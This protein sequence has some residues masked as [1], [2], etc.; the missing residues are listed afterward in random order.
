MSIQPFEFQ[1]LGRVIFGP[2]VLSDV[3]RHARQWGRRALV[4]TGGKPARA[5][6]LLE[7]L[8]EGRIS[9]HCFPIAS[10]PKISDVIDGAAQGREFRA[11][12]V[13]AFG[14]GSVID[15]AK[16]IAGMLTNEGPL[17]DYLE[18]VGKGDPLELPAAPWIAIPTTAGTGAEVTRNAVLSVPERHLKVSLRSNH[19][20]APLVLVDPELCLSLPPTLTAS[21]GM[22]ALTQ[23]IEPYVSAKANPMTDAYCV[24]GIPKVAAALPLACTAPT[25]LAARSALSLG[26][27]WSGIALTNAGLGAVHGFASPL[28]GLLGA[29]HGALCG[30]L[31]GPVMRVNIRALRDL[32]PNSPI[33]R[34]YADVAAWL[35]GRPDAKPEEGADAATFLAA[36]LGVPRL[37]TY[38]LHPAQFPEL[39][40]AAL[41][42]SSMKANPVLLTEE[43]LC[44]CLQEAF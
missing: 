40:Q 21:T 35:T 4:V 20:F 31:L 44:T 32:V 12:M 26:A 27:V 3:A 41:R 18:I 7:L 5:R 11:D 36:D 9:T 15:A 38:C 30:A 16:A 6:R 17:L 29:P 28:G 33:L 8:E 37:R 42:A 43:A 34:R 24:A 39:A 19:L 25:D 23:L 22:D 1:G 2:G 14:G 13:I 10:E